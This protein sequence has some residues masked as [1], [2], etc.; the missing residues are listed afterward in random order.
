M[1]R[2]AAGLLLTACGATPAPEPSPP[3][4]APAPVSD[5][6]EP[7]PAVEDAKPAAPPQEAPEVR[8][9][10][11]DAIDLDGDGASERIVVESA[12]VRAGPVPA[13]AGDAALAVP[14]ARCEV[15]E[16]VDAPCEVT[17]RVDGYTT[18]LVLPDFYFD[19]GFDVQRLDLDPKVP[20]EVLLFTQRGGDTEDPPFHFHVATYD[21]T[22]LT[23]HP[24]FRSY[25]YNSGAVQA[26]GDG[27]LVLTYDECPDATTVTYRQRGAAIDEVDRVVR[28]VAKP[29]SCAACPL[30][31]VDYAGAGFVYVGE[32]LRDLSSPAMA[33][34]QP[35]VLRGEAFAIV[36]G[37]VSMEL[38]ESKPERT[39]LD[40]VT[41]RWG[42]HEL[43]PTACERAPA[44]AYCAID[45][46]HQV[47]SPGDVLPL[48][49]AVPPG[50]PP[51]DVTLDVSGYYE[52][53]SDRP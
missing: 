51:E 48:A 21:G 31:F 7:A 11:A 24:L 41:L 28:R 4:P 40:A 18:T 38:R 6:A 2:A 39:S 17:L 12:V 1:K 36:D 42:D 34:T 29:E 50:P 33:T 45:G 53:L 23:M 10:W 14:F 47:L 26:P 49:F 5:P 3:Q 37:T 9:L 13:D 52:P 25:G 20:G 35:L 30:L 8:T 32:V 46:A 27:T 22:A 15:P 19:R 43:R 16:G 44:P